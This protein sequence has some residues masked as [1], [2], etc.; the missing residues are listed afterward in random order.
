[1]EFIAN[2]VLVNSVSSWL[3]AGTIDVLAGALKSVRT[4]YCGIRAK[5]WGHLIADVKHRGEPCRWLSHQHMVTWHQNTTTWLE[6]REYLKRGFT[7]SPRIDSLAGV[8]NRERATS[9]TPWTIVWRHLAA[10]TEGRIALFCKTLLGVILDFFQC[11]FSPVTKSDFRSHHTAN[12][13]KKMFNRFW[14]TSDFDALHK[15]TYL[16]YTCGSTDHS[17]FKG[18]SDFVLL[19]FKQTMNISKAVVG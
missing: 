8:V 10:A 6:R 7:R 12:P 19:Q 18:L 15:N 11:N 1:M 16:V 4:T 17:H 14:A 5:R 3:G 2:F 13:T 9:S